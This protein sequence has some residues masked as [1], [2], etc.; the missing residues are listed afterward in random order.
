M[1]KSNILLAT[2]AIAVLA[3]GCVKPT[4]DAQAIY[5]PAQPTYGTEQQSGTYQEATYDP[6]APGIIYEGTQTEDNPEITTGAV[7]AATTY[8][9]TY[10]ST[11]TSATTY[12]DTYG[13]SSSTATTYPDT[14][15]SSSSSTA[16]TYP[17][18]YGSTTSATTYPDT[19]GSSSSTA[20]TYPS[21][22]GSSTTYGSSSS[23]TTSYP[24]TYGSSTA[25]TATTYPDPYAS[26][27]TTATTYPDPYVTSSATT[28]YPATAS[29]SSGHAGGIQLQIAALKNYYTA[30]EYVNRLSLPPG[31]SAYVK[32]GA[33]NKVIITGI[34]S[35]AEANRL[36]ENRFPGAFIVHGGGASGGGY[37]SSST[38]SIT[39][40]VNNPYGTSSSTYSSS[41]NS[42]IGVQ[43][44]AFS[45]RSKAQSVANAQTGRYPATVKKIGGLYKVIL[46]GFSSESA[47][48]RYAKRVGGFIVFN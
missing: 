15:G 34:S 8:P 23:T 42:G 12:P 20:T 13:S 47:A 40:T 6:S 32:R 48:R 3:T 27:S 11:T 33:M 5:D 2:S 31:L 25:S 46:T 16:T 17:D 35:V 43:I 21:T 44:G 10:G 28:H 39:Y 38:H 4:Q 29:S 1:K 7:G 9:D 24:S 26:S 30:Q 36:K 45:S 37:T 19:Y 22:Y 18:T 14:Y 41:G